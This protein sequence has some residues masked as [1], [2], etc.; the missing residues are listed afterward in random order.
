MKYDRSLSSLQIDVRGTLAD[1]VVDWGKNNLNDN[2]L[3]I[4]DTIYG[5]EDD[6]HITVICGV[7]SPLQTLINVFKK[8]KS[9]KV[10]LRNI[11]LFQNQKY[12]VLKID[13]ES[14]KLHRLHRIANNDLI[15]TCKRPSFLPHITIAY[16]RKDCTSNVMSRVEPRLF[17]GR[18][19]QINELVYNPA[20]SEKHTIKLLK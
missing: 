8:E 16:L 7:T 9:F 4:N 15:H 11:T 3:V 14:E 12:D 18:Q 20:F 19:V 5:R 10:T 17:N 2:E 1:E 6:I 13:I